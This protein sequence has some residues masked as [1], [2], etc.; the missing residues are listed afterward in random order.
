M[1]AVEK[2]RQSAVGV[3]GEITYY[4]LMVP[5]IILFLSNRRNRARPVGDGGGDERGGRQ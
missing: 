1:S 2:L 4:R 3:L 5:F